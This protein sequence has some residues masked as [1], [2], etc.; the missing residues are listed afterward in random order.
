MR[1]GVRHRRDP[2]DLIPG[3]DHALDLHRSREHITPLHDVGIVGAVV[4]VVKEVL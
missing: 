2:D 1:C 3:S 4:M